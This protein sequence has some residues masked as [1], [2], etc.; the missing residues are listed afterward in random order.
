MARFERE[1]AKTHVRKRSEAIRDSKEEKGD[2]RLSSIKARLATRRVR[3][4][5]ARVDER[6]SARAY[7]ARPDSASLNAHG[8][9]ARGALSRLET[10]ARRTRRLR[11]NRRSPVI[12]SAVTKG[13][14]LLPSLCKLVR[15]S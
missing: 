10:I 1:N 5:H 8:E 4:R 9:L 12:F 14:L 6:K 2:P 13:P 7:S 3:N 11:T 15:G